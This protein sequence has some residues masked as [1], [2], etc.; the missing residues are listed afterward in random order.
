MDQ[1]GQAPSPIADGSGARTRSNVG[2]WVVAIAVGAVLLLA[3][4]LAGDTSEIDPNDPGWGD[5]AFFVSPVLAFAAAFVI[6]LVLMV[7]A[8][9]GLIDL[10]AR[11]AGRAM[12]VGLISGPII[13]FVIMV[14]TVV[15]LDE[16]V[17]T[18]TTWAFLTLVVPTICGTGV[19]V[20]AALIGR[21]RVAGPAGR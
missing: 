1:L 17:P 5:I 21:R 12:L 7:V 13:Y 6:G 15:A 3:M 16:S 20:I 19:T 11:I 10:T 14:I 8:W 4:W 9:L 2:W 18:S